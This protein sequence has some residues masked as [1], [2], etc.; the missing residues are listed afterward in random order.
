L[1]ESLNPRPRQARYQAALR[2]DKHVTL[3][4]KHFPTLDRRWEGS[5][6]SIH[7][8]CSNSHFSNRKA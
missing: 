3:I 6:F 5:G 2:A 1:L 7:F 8:H 4:L